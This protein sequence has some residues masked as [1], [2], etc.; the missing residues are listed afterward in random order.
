MRAGVARPDGGVLGRQPRLPPLL[1]RA[2]AAPAGDPRR[3]RAPAAGAPVRGACGHRFVARVRLVCMREKCSACACAHAGSCPGG[4]CSRACATSERAVGA[5]GVHGWWST[6]DKG[7]RAGW[8][9]RQC[10]RGW[11]RYTPGSPIHESGADRCSAA[12]QL[13]SSAAGA[14]SALLAL[15][16]AGAPQPMSV[17]TDSL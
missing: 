3:P 7:G 13:G 9:P 15:R 1:P 14:V 12:L 8:W 5:Q 16:W 11:R 17:A 2:R 6:L 4:G 10:G